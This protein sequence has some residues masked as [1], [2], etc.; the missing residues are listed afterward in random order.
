MK[1][2]PSWGDGQQAAGRAEGRT[3]AATA[4]RTG[5]HPKSPPRP[6]TDPL[7]SVVV[8]AFNAAAYIDDCLRSILTQ[9]G[10]FQLEVICVDDGS[11]DDTAARAGAHPGVR[12]LR[13]ANAGPSAARNRGIA[14]ARGEFI[15]FLDADDLWPAD[16]LA[17]QLT[18]LDTHPDVDLVCGDCALFDGSETLLESFFDD[19]GLDLA[20]WGDPVRV[21][22]PFAKLFQLNYLA[23]GALLIRRAC[24]AR[25]GGFDETMRLVEDLELWLRL[26]RHCSFAY[27]RQLCQRKRRHANNISADGEAMT[28]AYV[29]LLERQQRLHAQELRHKGIRVGARIAFEYCLLGDARAR[30]GDGRAARRWYLRALRRSPS[31]RPLWYWL[32]SL[33]TANPRASAP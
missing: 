21:L 15:A 19:A 9:R 6:A 17:S 4:P 31:L 26:A 16:R 30:D 13:Q 25:A 1:V 11:D 23:T 29:W 33:S 8:P 12:V 7:I 18:L 3:P 10:A 24:L 2:F 28:L 14:T 20:F 5:P 27:T 22:D 32:R